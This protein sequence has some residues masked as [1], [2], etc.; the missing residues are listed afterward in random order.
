M[1]VFS[2]FLNNFF[3]ISIC[4]IFL[5]YKLN[6]SRHQSYRNSYKNRNKIIISLVTTIEHFHVPH[7]MEQTHIPHSFKNIPLPNKHQYKKRKVGD[8]SGG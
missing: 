7:V 2:L 8:H 3:Q 5:I 4:N 6:F 1:N